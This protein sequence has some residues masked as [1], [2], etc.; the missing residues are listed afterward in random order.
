MS[1]EAVCHVARMNESCNIYEGVM[2]RDAMSR[3]YCREYWNLVTHMHDSY[4][5]YE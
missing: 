3:L 1:C 4:H 5:A 2:S